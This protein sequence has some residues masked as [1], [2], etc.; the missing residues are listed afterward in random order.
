MVETAPEAVTTAV[1]QIA[2]AMIPDLSAWYEGRRNKKG[3]VNS[4]V[5]CAGLYITEF[6]A[7]DWPLTEEVY[8][9]ASQ[10]RGAGKAK[11]A[12]ILSHHGETR[13]FTEEAGRT[14]R[15]TM[16]QARSLADVLN[17]SGAANG[18]DEL[19]APDRVVLACLL[20]A[21]FVER[22][23]DDFYGRK[24]INAQINPS[25]TIRA[26]VAA[27]LDAGRQ[28][29][30][31]AAGAVAQHL[32]GAK[33]EIRFPD[34]DINVENYTTADLQTGRAGD[35]Q[36]GDTAIHVTMS[37]SLQLFTGR[38]QHNLDHGFRSRVLVPQNEVDRAI[39]LAEE[40][41]ISKS[42]AVQSIEDFVGTNIE[43]VAN[44]DSQQI[45]VQMRELLELYNKRIDLA[46]SDKS[47][48]I[49]IPENL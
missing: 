2:V 21:W 1:Q 25:W 26:S 23:R 48:K 28:R 49:V 11:A 15:G 34:M 39:V 44:F 42:V 38:C 6:M 5:M 35:F 16:K 46:E 37:P 41:G 36:V 27:L 18:V 31:T 12:A 29:G 47:F 8:L 14:S 20:Q 40:A 10:V 43:E 4:N 22:V 45:K 24:K 13:K 19:T 3:G 9:A 7:T 32:V 33:L 30:G 17:A